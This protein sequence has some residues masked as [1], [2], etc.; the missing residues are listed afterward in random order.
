MA[1][2]HLLW[3]LGIKLWSSAR[4]AGTPNHWAIS[5]AWGGQTLKSLLWHLPVVWQLGNYLT[6]ISFICAEPDTE[7]KQGSFKKKMKGAWR[8]GSAWKAPAAL[9]EDLSLVPSS[10]FGQLTTAHNCSFRASP[11]THEAVLSILPR[12]IWR[13]RG[14]ELCATHCRNQQISKTEVFEPL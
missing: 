1:L 12:E 7:W 3:L 2:S 10:C 8:A 5:P 4:A 11:D 14:P 9:E 6:K 13:S